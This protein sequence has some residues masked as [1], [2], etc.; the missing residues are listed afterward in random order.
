MP[1]VAL[2]P[3]MEAPGRADEIDTARLLLLDREHC[4]S[5]QTLQACRIRQGAANLRLGAASLGTL[6]R[7]V[8]S[9]QGVMLIPEMAAAVE[10]RDLRLSRFRVPAPSRRIGLIGYGAAREQGWFAR[11]AALLVDAARAIPRPAA[12]GDRAPPAG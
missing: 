3:D 2:A 1:P 12:A 6:A 5:E 11:L 9:G 4:L 8:A 10:G 7:L